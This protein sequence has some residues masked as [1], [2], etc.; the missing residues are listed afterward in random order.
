LEIEKTFEKYNP[1]FKR[2][3]VSITVNHT[4]AGTPKLID[5]KKAVATMYKVAED[6]V[7][8]TEMKTQTGT[9]HTK[10]EVEIYDDPERAKQLVQKYIQ[11]RNTATRNEKKGEQPAA[12]KKEAKKK[13]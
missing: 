12:K 10:G 13:A 8:V 3:E 1:L 6:A 2:R 5:V 11:T 9:N 4:S 7:Y